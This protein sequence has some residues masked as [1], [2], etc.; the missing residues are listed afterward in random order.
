MYTKYLFPD[1]E[2]ELRAKLIYEAKQYVFDECQKR[3]HFI[4]K[5]GPFKHQLDMDEN[6]ANSGHLDYN[7]EKKGLKVIA[8]TFTTS[9]MDENGGRSLASVAVASFVNG[10]CELEEFIRI[11]NFYSISSPMIK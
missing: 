4:L 6:D 1:F 2:K 3:L 8:L 11:R 9:E 7:N 5:Q 10:A